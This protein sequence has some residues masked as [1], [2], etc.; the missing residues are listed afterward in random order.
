MVSQ[1][2][3]NRGIEIVV[4]GIANVDRYEL[5]RYASSEVFLVVDFPLLEKKV[6]ATR[7]VLLG[8]SKLII[9]LYF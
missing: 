7:N 3:K 2:I 1:A 8:P 9:F 5:S 4:I 6:L